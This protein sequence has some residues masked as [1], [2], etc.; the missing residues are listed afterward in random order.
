MNDDLRP[1][2]RRQWV[3]R[4]AVATAAVAATCLPAAGPPGRAAAPPAPRLGPAALSTTVTDGS[5]PAV[6]GDGRFVVFEGTID[7]RRTVYVTDRQSGSTT[8]L[9]PVPDGVRGGDTVL[10][11]VS[12]DGCVV[13][14]LSEVPFDLF[15]DD[16]EDARWD[17]YRLAQPH[18][19]GQPGA[20]ELVSTRADGIARDDV[21]GDVAP[22]VSGS[23]A[24]VAYTHPLDGAP[25][26]VM[27]I[28]VVDLTLPLGTPGRDQPVGGLPAEAP[29]TVFRYRGFTQP[30]LSANGRH[31][32]FRADATASAPL[33]GWGTGPVAGEWATSQVYVWDR[34]AVDPL[35]AVHLVSGRDGTASAAGADDPAISEDGRI[36]VY[37]SSDHGLADASYPPCT[38]TAAPVVPA[39]PAPPACPTQVFRFDRDTDGNGVFDEP[40]RRFPTAL[41]SATDVDG[42]GPAA[43]IAG[44]RFSW[45]P[46]VNVDGSQ[47][48]FVT[49]STNLLVE[50]V[51]GGGTAEDGD[52]LVA[53]VGSGALHRV[54]SRLA[55][56]PVPG[57]HGHPAM[58]DT[59]R[60][61]VFDTVVAGAFTGDGSLAG[62]HVVASSSP[63]NLSL[64]AAD[65]GTVLV[66]WDSAELYI[67]VL[68]DG[69]GAFR[70]RAVNSS[71]ANFKIRGGSCTRQV[72]VPAGGTCTVY[73][74]FNPTAPRVFN[75][76]I[77]VAEDGFEAVTVGAD[78]RGTGGEPALAIDPAGLDFDPVVVGAP[79]VR[80]TVDVENVSFAP[81]SI[82]SIRI[83]GPHA[84]D[85]SVVR[86]ACTNRA[87]NPAATCSVE[88]E[89]HPTAGYHRTAILSV[90]TPSGPYTAAILSGQGR[91]AP[92]LELRAATVRAGGVLGIGGA[93]FPASSG[94]TLRF[95]DTGRVFAIV[96]SNESGVVLAEVAVPARERGGVRT[97]VASGPD[98]AAATIDVTIERDVVMPG[99][100]GYGL[101]A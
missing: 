90:S 72:V 76:R 9:S 68:N 45:A 101:G 96:T 18:C 1:V 100:P 51:G 86:Q 48:V 99:T 26:G 91:Y 15:R 97:L 94:V 31:L 64:A 44:D 47:V 66:G 32:A 87:L 21:A 10:P 22:S 36:V 81:T 2:H 73:V 34:A 58:S 16:D 8:E 4:A 38:V 88:V 52:L 46:A 69:P 54:S 80:R 63:P 30:A 28:T 41:I 42:A 62:R 65:F 39:G 5:R 70:P 25:D 75:A 60:V 23:G 19:G 82:S 98:D 67:S 29:N 13:V 17:V 85:F 43:A 37:R 33:P 71:S 24:V 92:R 59:G 55:A 93:G 49:D 57:A 84:G 78:V 40:P 56:T 95:A 53:D 20:W 27:T 14:A 89:F 77:D 79:G 74:V 61:I 35:S 3:I 11:S 83:V 7:G 50:H 6:S 12:A